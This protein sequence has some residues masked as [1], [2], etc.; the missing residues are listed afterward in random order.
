MGWLRNCRNTTILCFDF[1]SINGKLFYA[2]NLLREGQISNEED[3]IKKAISKLQ[4]TIIDLEANS[5]IE[6]VSYSYVCV[7]PDVEC[8]HI[9]EVVAKVLE[10]EPVV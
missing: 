4:A 2:V 6:E 9:N 3:E 5:N 1:F 8:K 10:R 7:K